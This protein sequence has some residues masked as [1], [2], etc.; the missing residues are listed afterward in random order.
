MVPHRGVGNTVSGA[1]M[2]AQVVADRRGSEV[3]VLTGRH[4]H[5]P[6]LKRS[7]G[8]FLVAQDPLV[9]DAAARLLL[10]KLVL[11]DADLVC[12]CLELV[13]EGRVEDFRLRGLLLIIVGQRFA[14]R[15]LRHL[16][17]HGLRML[18]SNHLLSRF[19]IKLAGHEVLVG[20]QIFV[21]VDD[22]VD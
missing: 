2:S 6:V 8:Q 1:M 10:I 21:Q 4:A 11:E 7:V 13:V 14:A 5:L 20:V 22:L 3:L 19:F 17:S 18:R 12:Q 9:V 16:Q 15:V